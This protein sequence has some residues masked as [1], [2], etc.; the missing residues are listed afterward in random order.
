MVTSKVPR[1]LGLEG[2]QAQFVS[3]EFTLAY[4]PPLHPGPQ[5]KARIL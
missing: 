1:A 3:P 4:L 5:Q 2:I